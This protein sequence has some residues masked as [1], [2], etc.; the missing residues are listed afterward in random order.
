MIDDSRGI[1]L[2]VKYF[3]HLEMFYEII[4]DQPFSLI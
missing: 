3:V 2:S 4:P 1:F